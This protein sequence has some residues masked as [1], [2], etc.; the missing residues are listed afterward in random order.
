MACKRFSRLI[1]LEQKHCHKTQ[2]KCQINYSSAQ[3]L[4]L[5]KEENKH[6]ISQETKACF[7][8]GC[9]TAP[10]DEKKSKRKCREID[11]TPFHNPHVFSLRA[12]LINA[13]IWIFFDFSIGF[14][15]SFNRFS[16]LLGKCSKSAN[17]YYLHVR[18]FYTYSF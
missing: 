10:F 9:W 3:F 2:V 8:K 4:P 1:K 17:Y 14:Q 6:R 12:D 18:K 5:E 13:V 11:S 15:F 16:R 7:W